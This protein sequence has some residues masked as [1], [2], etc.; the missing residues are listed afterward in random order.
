VSSVVRVRPP[1]VSALLFHGSDL[2]VGG[3]FAWAGGVGATNIARW[4]GA[5]WHALGQGVLAVPAFTP[6]PT[7]RALALDLT[8]S[9]SLS[10]LSP[11]FVGGTFVKADGS[12]ASNL[13]CWDGH[14]WTPVGEGMNTAPRLAALALNHDELYVGGSFNY[15]GGKPASDFALWHR[16]VALQITGADE[17]IHFFWP[18]AADGYS[19]Q[20]TATLSPASW[21]PVT[22]RPVLRGNQWS[23][24]LTKPGSTQFHRLQKP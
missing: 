10:P 8:R 12:P 15:A 16:W 21:Q 2:Y 24:T 7:V 13:A 1:P 14:Q 17:A 18:A 9:P 6:P 5:S 3:D 20:A 23:V 11:L 22:N 19:L 4:D